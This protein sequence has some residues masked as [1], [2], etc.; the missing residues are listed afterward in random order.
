MDG[1][2]GLSI[3]GETIAIGSWLIG[4]S[5]KDL[6]N[7]IAEQCTGL[8]D[9]KRTEEY[10]EGQLIYE[11]DIVECLFQIGSIM[12]T[13]ENEIWMREDIDSLDLSRLGSETLP[14]DEICKESTYFHYEALGQVIFA[15]D[16][17]VVNSCDVSFYDEMGACF[18]WCHCRVI[19]NIHENPELLSD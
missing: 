10:P 12:S 5:V 19:G 7:I 17:F 8:R 11:G 18:S 3:F 13:K 16:G 14:A 15:H 2:D 6:D 4:T 9:C 1:V